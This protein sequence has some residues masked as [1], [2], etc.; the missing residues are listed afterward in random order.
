MMTRT[1]TRST[2]GRRTILAAMVMTL[3]LCL[4]IPVRAQTT[5]ERPVPDDEP[6]IEKNEERSPAVNPY[7]PYAHKSAV[8][9]ERLDEQLAQSLASRTGDVREKALQLAVT[10]GTLY[11]EQATYAETVPELV[12]VYVRS[13][14]ERHRIMALSALHAIG[15][16]YGMEQLR[17]RVSAE[18]SERIRQLTHAALADYEATH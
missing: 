5:A 17:A 15:D 2:A 1:P 9:W 16:P 6:E 11:G 8:W 4:T 10:M 12:R 3:A 13:V 18:P 14:D 7:A